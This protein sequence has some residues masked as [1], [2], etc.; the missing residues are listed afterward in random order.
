MT[1]VECGTMN[2]NIMYG[3]YVRRSLLWKKD[4]KL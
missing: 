3:Y 4:T 1:R 2:N